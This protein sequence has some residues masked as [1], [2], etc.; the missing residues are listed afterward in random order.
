MSL[1]L[2]ANHMLVVSPRVLFRGPKAN[3]DLNLIHVDF[4]YDMFAILSIG[5]QL[6]SFAIKLQSDYGYVIFECRWGRRYMKGNG[7]GRAATSFMPL[8]YDMHPADVTH[9][10]KIR[11]EIIWVANWRFRVAVFATKII[12]LSTTMSFYSMYFLAMSCH[13]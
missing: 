2:H 5:I 10:E 7:R 12:W 9:D 4:R 11:K 8:V 3:V 1:A 13:V 6:R